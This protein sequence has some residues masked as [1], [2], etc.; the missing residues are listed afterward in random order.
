MPRFLSMRAAR[1]SR[2][3]RT[4]LL[5]VSLALPPSLAPPL[6]ASGQTSAPTAG[7]LLDRAVRAIGGEDAVH[8]L[9]TARSRGRTHAW[10]LEQSE[11]PEG[12]WI[13]Q[14]GEL[15]EWVDVRG[16]R[17]RSAKR[18][19]SAQAPGGS[20]WVEIYAH[21]VLAMQ[22]GERTMPG[23]DAWAVAA[24]ERLALGPIAVLLTARASSPGSPWRTLHE[25]VLHW[26]VPFAWRDGRV[27][28]L[29]NART[30]LPS[31][32]RL[33]RSY[34]R[35]AM[36]GVWGEVLT[37]TRFHYWKLHAG[38]WRYPHQWDT[39]RNGQPLET[40]LVLEVEPAAEVAEDAFA[41]STEVTA[42]W[43]QRTATTRLS[44]APG[45]TAEPV[46][47]AEGVVL[48]PGWW[49]VMLVEQHD[50]VVVVE[51]PLSSEYSDKVLAEVERRFPGKP[52]K[53]VINTSDAW[54]HIGGLRTY[55][56]LGIPIWS[57]PRNGP[58]L[59]RLLTARYA[60]RPDLLER[61]PREAIF[62]WVDGTR[63]I[64]S[65]MN[66]LVVAPIDGE[67]SDRM[68]M[69][70]LPELALLH[71]ADLVFPPR[72]GQVGFFMPGYLEELRDAAGHE[73]FDVQQLVSMHA[74]PLPWRDVLEEIERVH[75]GSGSEE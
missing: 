59:R 68:L 9:A 22:R 50:G 27:E 3:L 4:I 25:E 69:V 15:E 8:R 46:D 13:V 24:E 52:V 11:R 49:N 14:Y 18:V 45:D 58:L 38:G 65:S 47:I 35:D 44:V 5:L 10:A 55:A 34:A 66:P 54:P 63:A 74:G 41:I 17:S 16:D 67:W 73:G 71:G 1:P 20:A 57:Q 7:E 28:L 6:M 29:L 26:A 37:E 33:W 60:A 70:W 75:D 30:G 32:V 39:Y 23:I 2:P 51:A 72:P 56:A 40:R 19:V 62:E 42:G 43:S 36:L 64:D 48:Y 12:P 31:A 53:A 61:E 21:G